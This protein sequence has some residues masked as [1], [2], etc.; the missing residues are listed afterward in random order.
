MRLSVNKEVHLIQR[1][2]FFYSDISSRLVPKELTSHPTNKTSNERGSTVPVRKKFKYAASLRAVTV[3]PGLRMKS[4]H[5]IVIS[6]S[7]RIESALTILTDAGI[8][9]GNASKE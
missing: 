4:S 7:A 6:G 3:H 8:Q 1:L 9:A 5:E 2:S